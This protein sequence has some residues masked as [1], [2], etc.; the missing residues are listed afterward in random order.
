MSDCP[1]PLPGLPDDESW[2]LEI[3]QAALARKH[4]DAPCEACGARRWGVAHQLALISA[5][6]EAGRFVPGRGVD[7]VTVYCKRCGLL[8]LHAASVLLSD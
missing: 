2:S 5:L 1:E 7:A 3:H 8:R 6:D 4:A